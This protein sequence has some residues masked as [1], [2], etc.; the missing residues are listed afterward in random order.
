MEQIADLSAGVVGFRASGQLDEAR[1][2]SA[3]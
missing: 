1:A 2:W 3:G